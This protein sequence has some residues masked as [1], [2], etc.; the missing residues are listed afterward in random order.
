M[1]AVPAV[2]LAAS[3]ALGVAPGFAGVVAHSVNEAG[4]GGAFA[5]PHWT[6]AGALLGLASTVL[7]LGLAALAVSRPE[8]LGERS[9]TLPLRHL[10]S[11]HIGDYVAWVLAGAAL[12]GVL[13]LPGITVG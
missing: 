6:A 12:L 2:L 7:A 10:Q 9:W 3:L 5:S 8:L 4:S 11:G 13:V 1:T